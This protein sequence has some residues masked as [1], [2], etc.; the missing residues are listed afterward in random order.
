MTQEG[1]DISLTK[2]EE[3]QLDK[4]KQKHRLITKKGRK[5]ARQRKVK[6]SDKEGRKTT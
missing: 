2:E 4:G 5:T 1:K 6:H 3:K